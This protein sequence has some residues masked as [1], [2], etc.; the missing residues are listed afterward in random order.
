MPTVAFA[1]R[2]GLLEAAW[3]TAVSSTPGTTWLAGLLASVQFAA[4]NQF[5]SAAPVQLSMM[6]VMVKVTV[7]EA[8]FA[9]RP[10]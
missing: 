10:G 1:V 4:L 5:V 9:S 7:N 2:T 6:P 8:A 3:M